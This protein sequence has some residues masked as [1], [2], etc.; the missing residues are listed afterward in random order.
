MAYVFNPFTGTLDITGSG[1]GGAGLGTVVTKTTTYTAASEYTILCDATGG[2]FDID[3]PAAA[4]STN[5]IYVI[6]KI[7]SSTNAVTVDGDGGETID[8][9]A[10]QALA[11]QYQSITITC[12]GSNWFII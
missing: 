4:A 9:A 3:L 2:P 5:K 6:K 12:D 7:D 1:G 10:T 11:V 8:G